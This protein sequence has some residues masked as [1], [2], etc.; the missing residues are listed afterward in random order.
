MVRAIGALAAMLTGFFAAWH[1][2]ELGHSPQT[3]WDAAQTVVIRNAMAFTAAWAQLYP[4]AAR[5]PARPAIDFSK[6]R[7]LIVAAGTKPTGGFR[8]AL[9]E[10][11]V[12]R[13]S[14]QINVTLFTP[15]EGCSFTEALTSPAIAI[16]VPLKPAA[17]RVISHERADTVRCN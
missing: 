10:A 13:D 5:R 9:S 16:A 17:F 2:T 4:L 11:L 7:V 8:M 14:A 3:G 12:V 1:A 6:Y 15:G